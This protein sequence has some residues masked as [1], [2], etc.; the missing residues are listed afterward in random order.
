MVA[1]TADP[2]VGY[3]RGRLTVKDGHPIRRRGEKYFV[4]LC[5]C[6]KEKAIAKGSLVSGRS[7][8]CGCY[9]SELVSALHTTHGK[10]KS[11]IYAVWN[12][13]KQRCNVPTNIFYAEY[14]GRGIKVSEEWMDF[15]NF[16][17]DMGDCPYKGATL[18]RRDN[19][20]NYCKENV[21]WASRVEQAN[22][23]RNSVRFEFRGEQLS[24]RQ[25]ADKVGMNLNSLASRVYGQSMTIEDAVS[26]PILTPAECA[27]LKRKQP[28]Y[29]GRVEGRKLYQDNK[30][31]V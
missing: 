29:R 24:L 4:M 19:N 1:P 13:M 11:P 23:K 26:L 28:R 20:A 9:F 8:S 22:N 27:T 2:E 7:T 15:E 21:Y 16:Y 31:N 30:V 3:R 25:I 12:M 14:G 6:G 17:R 10:S 18:E 5:D